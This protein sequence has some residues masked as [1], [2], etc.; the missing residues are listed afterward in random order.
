MVV[1]CDGFPTFVMGIVQVF[2]YDWIDCRG[3]SRSVPCL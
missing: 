1:L 3:P 2:C